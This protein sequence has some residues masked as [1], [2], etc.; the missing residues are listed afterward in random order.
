L[1]KRANIVKNDLEEELQEVLFEVSQ[2]ESHFKKT[3]RIS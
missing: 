3:L 2:I 1:E